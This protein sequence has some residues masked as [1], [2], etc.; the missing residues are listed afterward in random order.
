[1]SITSLEI[2]GQM[3]EIIESME[4]DAGKYLKGTKSAA[5]RMRKKSSELDKL[6]KA[7]RKKSVEE[8]KK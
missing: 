6:C 1:M 7:F 2:Y 5:G 8:C 4:E 3:Q